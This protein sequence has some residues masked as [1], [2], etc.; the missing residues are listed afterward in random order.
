MMRQLAL[1]LLVAMACREPD[2][3]PGGTDLRRVRVSF[4]P[5]LSW[6]PLMIAD[7]EGFFR[8]EGIEIEFVSAMRPEESLVA[9]ITRDLDV[10][11]GPIHAGFL[12]A[13]AQG[14]RIRMAAGQGHLSGNGCTYYG[15]VLRPGLDTAGPV[16]IK[17]M[18]ASQ[19]GASRF[20]VERML[21]RH[22]VDLDAIETVR[23][24]DAVQ[25]M[26][27]ETGA[28]DAVAVSEPGLTRLK[29]IGTLW[30]AGQEALPD[31]QWA[32]LAF[33]ERLLYRERDLGVRFLRAYQRGVAQYRQGKT[34]RNVAIIAKA[35]GE[36]EDIT[37]EACWPEFR[38]DSRINWESI[39]DFQ[40]W[41][42][43]EGL[44]EY[45]LTREQA[46]DSTFLDAAADTNTVIQP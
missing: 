43:D 44:M 36:S 16:M 39:R 29:Q 12:S 3:V 1:L 25:A 9:L 26:S 42:N 20:V 17:R 46:W 32:A 18:R 37:R 6:G 19:D 33:G 21:A 11:P 41:A 10:R 30:A 23:L 5:H 34:D 28:I 7:A 2:A 24:P 15:I 35:T 31:F 14:A 22:D 27:L 13:I 38:A 40:Q 4:N 45:T 8:D